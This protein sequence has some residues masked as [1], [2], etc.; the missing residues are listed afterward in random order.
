MADTSTSRFHRAYVIAAVTLGALVAAAAFRSSTGVLLEPIERE[1]GWSRATTSGA[2][3]LNLVIYG[4][5]APFAAA[6][7]ESWGVRRTV[8][9]SLLVV[10][11]ASALTCVMTSP[12]QLWLLWG[13]LI[14]VG[15]GAMALTFGA[16]MANRWFDARRGLVTGIF[17]AANA[18]GQLL[19]LPAIAAAAS[20]PGWRYAALAVAALAVLMAVLVMAF[21]RDRPSDVGL[22]PYGAERPGHEPD[23]TPTN[24][25]SDPAEA[26]P[27]A[28]A[29]R[30]QLVEETRSP[31]W[32]AIDVLLRWRANWAF[33]ALMLTFFVCG[34]S[35]NGLVQTHF[36][37][38]AHDLGM[39]QT[40]AAWLLALVGIFDIIGTIASGWLTDRMDSRVLLAVYYAGRGLSLL[41]VNGLLA[42]TIEP[43]M[44][45]FIVFYGLDWVATV[46]PTV[47]L[48][49]KHFGMADSGVA[50]GWTFAAHM[51]G[52]GIGAS[53]AGQMRT[54][55]G[56]YELAWLTAAVLCFA[57]SVIALSIP[58]RPAAQ[59]R[60]RELSPV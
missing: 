15:T 58:R 50:F 54:H 32:T 24:E 20:G 4:L 21:L 25:W 27:G 23:A 40:T 52:A 33:S 10:G 9:I 34:W 28:E 18:T 59:V 11:A 8:S 7:M 60:E 42:A 30:P 55:Q 12:W 57:A 16:I 56:T 36:V 13:L 26:A 6:V 5:I 49:R 39:P 51:F 53:V 37:P 29:V 46:P 22:R 2:V 31:F 43:P 35:T 17:S 3:S 41:F 44:W 48:C 1:F 14:G 19:F 47:A 45:A 38:A